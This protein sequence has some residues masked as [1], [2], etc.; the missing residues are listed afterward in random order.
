MTAPQ[1][2]SSTGSRSRGAHRRRVR[3][4]PIAL[5]VAAGTIAGTVTVLSSDD[6]AN[7]STEYGRADD[8]STAPRTAAP[9]DT[10]PPAEEP[11]AEPSATKQRSRA[12]RY[13][14]EILR[15]VNKARKQHGCEPLHNDKRLAKAARLHSEDMKAHNFYAHTPPGG[16]PDPKERMEAQG[17]ED[18]HAENIDAWE[19]T[20]EGAFRAWMESPG[21]RKNILSCS[22][23]ASGV[24]VAIG[25]K[26]RAYW[27]QDFGYK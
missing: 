16:G 7:A 1:P 18:A 25:G 21:H 6:G 17:Y 4:V 14:A 19:R 24:G 26:L 13:E 8:R 12:A 3:I 22:S 10:A 27:T 5:A 9:A 20:P 2:G 15:L 11:T 23:K